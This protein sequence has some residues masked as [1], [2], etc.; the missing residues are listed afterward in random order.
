VKQWGTVEA[1][2]QP[3]LTNV[4]TGEACQQRTQVARNFVSFCKQ[5]IER[6]W[7]D[8]DDQVEI[9]VLVERARQQ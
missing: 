4:L 8:R 1:D 2:Q 6:G 7:F 3:R 9:A 5:N